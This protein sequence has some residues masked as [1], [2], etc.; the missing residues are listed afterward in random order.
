MS[1]MLG[2]KEPGG[3]PHARACMGVVVWEAG[4]G[5]SPCSRPALQPLAL[6][7]WARRQKLLW[8]LRCVWHALI[9]ALIHWFSMTEPLLPAGC[10]GFKAQSCPTLYD[11]MD[12]SPA[13]L[14]C[15]WDFPGKHTGAGCH[16]LLQ[17]IFLTQGS[18]PHLLHHL[19]RQADSSP[20]WPKDTGAADTALALHSQCGGICVWGKRGP[21]APV[22]SQGLQGTRGDSPAA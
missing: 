8:A 9:Y 21:G 18:N 2:G 22:L 11:P 20:L 4:A 3:R 6:S 17:G 15:P 13:R 1:G 5:P 19:R 12:C 10:T 16:L 7:V 14:L